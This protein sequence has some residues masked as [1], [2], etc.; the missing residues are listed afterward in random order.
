[1]T[2]TMEMK[3][4]SSSS[5][6]TMT[7]NFIYSPTEASKHHIV[8]EKPVY[9]K[10]TV[11]TLYGTATYLTAKPPYTKHNKHTHHNQPQA[12]HRFKRITFGRIAVPPSVGAETP[13]SPFRVQLFVCKVW[14]V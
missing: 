2:M 7:F 10:K 14:K 12:H 4:K 8:N 3:M 11:H 6:M 1:M 5:T 9:Q 13:V